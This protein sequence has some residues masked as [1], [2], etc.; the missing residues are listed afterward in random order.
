[1]ASCA[2]RVQFLREWLYLTV[3]IVLR[4]YPLQAAGRAAA[5]AS[6][7]A[8]AAKQKVSGFGSAAYDA[9]V[10]VNSGPR[11]GSSTLRSGNAAPQLR[12]GT[13]AP[14]PTSCH[15][16]AEEQATKVGEQALTR[17]GKGELL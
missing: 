14:R 2:S 5:T 11:K 6:E 1:M 9:A 17:G 13:C 10:Q 12:R 16:Q 7:T 3:L 4:Y 15:A 8:E